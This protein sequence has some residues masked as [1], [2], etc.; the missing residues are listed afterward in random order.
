M[1]AL[2]VRFHWQNGEFTN[3]RMVERV[4]CRCQE[5]IHSTLNSCGREFRE[6][7]G[8]FGF[9]ACMIRIVLLK[10]LQVLSFIHIEYL[11]IKTV[12]MKRKMNDKKDR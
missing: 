3:L 12:N 9:I 7:S 5:H 6:L 10:R 8:H 11:L 2:K 4:L 1:K